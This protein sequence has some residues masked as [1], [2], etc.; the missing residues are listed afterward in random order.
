MLLNRALKNSN[1][2]FIEALFNSK[3]L[4]NSNFM[5]DEFVDKLEIRYGLYNYDIF[6]ELIDKYF[7]SET[8]SFKDL[9][10]EK[11]VTALKLKFDDND[12]IIKHFTE[13]FLKHK[14]FK[15]DNTKFM[16]EL[17]MIRKVNNNQEL[18]ELFLNISLSHSSFDFNTN[19]FETILRI[20]TE[21]HSIELTKYT[22]EKSFQQKTF[23]F[24]NIN[25]ENCL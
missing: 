13:K 10:F 25:F 24:Q 20:I 18:L 1:I 9:N 23:N 4:D 15:F 17:I 7:D 2:Y 8:F 19:E 14:N 22:L 12:Y 16:N 11:T 6:I 3:L 5:F 21:Y